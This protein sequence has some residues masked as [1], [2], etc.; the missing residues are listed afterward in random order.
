MEEFK[1]NENFEPSSSLKKLWLY[2]FKDNSAITGTI[3][4]PGL[5][6]TGRYILYF[7]GFL[8][9]LALEAWAFFTG[10]Q[11]GMNF[12]WVIAAIIIDFFLAFFGHRKQ[13]IVCENRNRIFIENDTNNLLKLKK[14]IRNAEFYKWIFWI[15]IIVSAIVKIYFVNE[16][17]ADFDIL[18]P[19]CI[20]YIF[21]AVL[22]CLVTGYFFYSSVFKIRWWMQHNKYSDN[23]GINSHSMDVPVKFLIGKE[24]LE[25]A[26]EKKHEIK[27]LDDGNFYFLTK[28]L[29]TDGELNTLIIRQTF[30][31][32]KVIIAKKGVELQLQMLSTEPNFSPQK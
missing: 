30:P 24:L 25:T 29:L 10:L 31:E 8:L 32:Q 18:L 28:G 1:L 19:V 17:G 11:E 21:A 16:T 23:S 13:D 9:I 14:K 26:I 6:N 27:L 12:T 7:V 15:F 20:A 5:F 22:H 2:T 3:N 4:L